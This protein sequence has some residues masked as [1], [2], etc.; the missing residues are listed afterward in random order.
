MG[1]RLYR[2]FTKEDM[3]IANKNMKMYSASLV[4][5]ECKTGQTQKTTYHIINVTS[6]GKVKF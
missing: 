1:K 4:I 5:K 6:P 3:W 2:H